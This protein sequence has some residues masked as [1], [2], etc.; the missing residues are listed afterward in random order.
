MIDS[1]ASGR[2]DD[3][4]AV[5]TRL[6]REF[7]VL[8]TLLTLGLGF[9]GVWK[10]GGELTAASAA[11]LATALFLGVPGILHPPWVRPLYRLLMTITRPIG[12]VVGVALLAVIFFMVLTPLALVLRLTGRDPLRLRRPLSDSLWIKR[13]T[14]DDVRQ[15]LRQY[16]KQV[17]D[18]GDGG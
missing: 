13:W 12:H 9:L 10:R 16:Q 11:L 6:L 3:A 15:Y 7:A 14:D 18:S 8:L 4:P 5:T 1:G 17:I 2:R